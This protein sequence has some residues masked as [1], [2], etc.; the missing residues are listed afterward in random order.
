[1]SSNLTIAERLKQLVIDINSSIDQVIKYTFNDYMEL[2][3]L[4]KSGVLVYETNTTLDDKKQKMVLELQAFDIL[5]QRLEHIQT[6]NRWMDNDALSLQG[7]DTP[8]PFNF[9]KLN[10]LQ[11]EVGCNEYTISVA[12]IRNII[13]EIHLFRKF[14]WPLTV[15]SHVTLV[16]GLVP[17]INQKFIEAIS[18]CTLSRKFNAECV[19]QLEGLYSMENEREVLKAYLTNNDVNGVEI[20]TMLA[21]VHRDTSNIDL[22]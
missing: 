4:I 13:E 14:D 20:Q 12:H 6:I 5:R 22:F 18:L 8:G 19:L 17:V 11:F 9:L 2:T 10:Q 7:S 1:M 15:L 3:N 21:S 16:M